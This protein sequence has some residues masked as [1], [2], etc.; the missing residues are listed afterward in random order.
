MSCNFMYRKYRRFSFR[1][2]ADLS[3]SFK[4]FVIVRVCLIALNVK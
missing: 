3:K 1:D 2:E 4:V